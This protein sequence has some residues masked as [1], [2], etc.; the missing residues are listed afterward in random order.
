MLG[1][2]FNG[3]MEQKNSPALLSQ[4]YPTPF[5]RLSQTIQKYRSSQIETAKTEKNQFR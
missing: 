3:F 4:V 1:V 2:C 5:N